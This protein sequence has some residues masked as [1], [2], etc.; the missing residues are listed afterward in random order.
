MSGWRLQE[1]QHGHRLISRDRQ[2]PLALALA[3]CARETIAV[4][5]FGRGNL[6]SMSGSDRGLDLCLGRLSPRRPAP[7]S[8]PLHPSGPG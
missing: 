5:K 4:L 6:D 8:L 7:R 1:A 3:Q 2:P